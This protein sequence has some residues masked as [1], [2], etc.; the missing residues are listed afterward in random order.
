MSLVNQVKTV[1]LLGLLT[2]LLLGVGFMFGGKTGLFVALL[3]SLIMNFGMYWFSDKIV[4]AMYKAKPVTEKENP[5]L[6]KIVDEVCA[7]SNMPKPKVYIIPTDAANAFATGRSPNH[8]AV[9]CTEGIMKLLKD[10]ELKGVIAHEISHVKNRDMLVTTIA[11]TIAGVISYL[12]TMAQWS[13]IFGS[14]D[15]EGKGNFLS[16]IILAILTPI[17][18]MIIQLAISRSREYLADE[19]GARTIKN[20]SG[21]AS[22]LEKLEGEASRK[23]M[24]MGTEAT[25]SLFIVNPLR[26]G[27][28]LALLST[29]PPL[30]ERV[31]RLRAMKV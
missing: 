15:E 11:A 12:A 6:H 16:L 3:F 2:G 22:A 24:R 13:A 14:R 9:A 27:G 19:T 30:K 29:H 28:L 1:L 17:I 21:L 4:L 31:R 20:P 7:A 8:A 23:P 10:D 25:A 5:K 26:G 18:A